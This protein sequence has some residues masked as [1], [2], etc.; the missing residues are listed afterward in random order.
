VDG[1][2]EQGR[3][4]PDRAAQARRMFARARSALG[5][6]DFEYRQVART[7][8]A[9][10]GIL[11]WYGPFNAV[12][13][14][15]HAEQGIGV[16][17]AHSAAPASTGVEGASNGEQ[18]VMDL[19]AVEPRG[20]ASAVDL[21]AESRMQGDARAYGSSFSRAALLAGADRGTLLVSGTASIGPDG[22]S[23]H[24]ADPEAQAQH[25]LRAVGALLGAQGADWP[26]LVG[27][28]L[29]VS[30]LEALHAFDRAVARTG[31]GPLPLVPVLADLCRPELLVEMDAIVQVPA[32]S[33]APAQADTPCDPSPPAC[34]HRDPARG[35]P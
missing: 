8:L 30:H 32:H 14:A 19:L 17:G 1:R 26:D 18:C 28:T 24:S 7:W 12:R 34:P 4:E 33:R 35:G 29:Y 3:L 22:Q 25:T 6:L 2:D 31:V 15:F 16:P 9:L 21:I 23:L 11:E 10:R 20:G 5:A 27:G 13:S